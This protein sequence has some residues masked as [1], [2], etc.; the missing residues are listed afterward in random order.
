MSDV[1]QPEFDEADAIEQLT[2]VTIDDEDALSLTQVR[3]SPDAEADE[4][5]LLEQA[6]V[7]PFDDEPELG[8]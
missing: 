8:R 3:L 2:P 7:V 6:I 4:A 1:T 5:D